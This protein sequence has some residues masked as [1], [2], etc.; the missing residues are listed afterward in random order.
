[1]IRISVAIESVE[2]TRAATR[3]PTRNL[4]PSA[5]EQK[6]IEELQDVRAT[7]DPGA[8]GVL[9]LSGTGRRRPKG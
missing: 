5:G 6:A 2:A 1:M 8:P 7:S 4:S 3:F 9:V